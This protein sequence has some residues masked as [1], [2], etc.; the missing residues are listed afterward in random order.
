MPPTMPR[1]PP[2]FDSG[3]TIPQ[4]F[5]AASAGALWGSQPG[6]RWNDMRRL[7]FWLRNIAKTLPP[8][9]LLPHAA[10]VLAA[11][12]QSLIPGPVPAFDQT[13][14][15]LQF[16]ATFRTAA[17]AAFERMQPPRVYFNTTPRR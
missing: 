17:I 12:W 7:G 9:D 3:V 16:L 14:K 6:R 1:P 13:D 10:T 2:T 4:S 11:D 15:A 8:A 5:K